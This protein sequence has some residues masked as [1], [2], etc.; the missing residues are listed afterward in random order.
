MKRHRFKQKQSLAWFYRRRTS[1][2]AKALP[3]G[4]ARE[5][6]LVRATQAEIGVQMSQW[7]RSPSL[8]TSA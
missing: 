3:P 4:A 8:K 2:E 7:L 1:E 5:A 6:I